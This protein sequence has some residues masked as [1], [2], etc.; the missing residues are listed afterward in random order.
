M[1]ILTKYD[2][3]MENKSIVGASEH[4]DICQIIALEDANKI[5]KSHSI[6]GVNT[7]QIKIVKVDAGL[8]IY[9]KNAD[10]VILHIW[11]ITRIPTLELDL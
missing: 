9:Y 8:N 1:F 5:K 6:N 11:T 7:G 10:D 4:L 2:Q 3:N